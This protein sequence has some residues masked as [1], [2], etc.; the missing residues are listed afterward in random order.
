MYLLSLI[1]AT[2]PTIFKDWDSEVQ[3]GYYN[4]VSTLEFMRT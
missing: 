1:A 2:I 3:A 4:K